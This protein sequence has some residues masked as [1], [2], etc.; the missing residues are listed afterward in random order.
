LHE[1]I[2]HYAPINTLIIVY[3]G[4]ARNLIGLHR[5]CS[6]LCFFPS[7]VLALQTS[8]MASTERLIE[9]EIGA[10]FQRTIQDERIVPRV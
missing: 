2:F 4:P 3:V 6:W 1:T 9:A 8:L 7:D 10:A 5:S